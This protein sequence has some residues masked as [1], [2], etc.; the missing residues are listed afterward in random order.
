[1][2]QVYNP[3]NLYELLA[4][5]KCPKRVDE[6]GIVG[7]IGEYM[8]YFG[9]CTNHTYRDLMHQLLYTRGYIALQM[10]LEQHITDVR[11]RIR[12]EESL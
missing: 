9:Y 3:S 6:R 5:L 1:M 7:K 8:L 11:K 12:I 4:Y 10:Q 2:S